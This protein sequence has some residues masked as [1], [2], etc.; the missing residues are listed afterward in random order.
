MKVMVISGSTD[1]PD[2]GH[3]LAQPPLLRDVYLGLGWIA[4]SS[5]AA[6]CLAFNKYRM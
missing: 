1:R 6:S 5:S 3:R 2:D 4:G